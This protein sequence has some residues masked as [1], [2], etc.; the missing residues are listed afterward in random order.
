MLKSASKYS[1]ISKLV[2]KIA[3]QI[4]KINEKFV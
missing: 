1:Y 2:N 4:V 3:K